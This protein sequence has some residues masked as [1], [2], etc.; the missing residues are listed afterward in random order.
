MCDQNEHFMFNN[1]FSKIASF[2]RECGRI[3]QNRAGHRLQYGACALHTR[4]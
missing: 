2:V 4:W 1:G 3:V